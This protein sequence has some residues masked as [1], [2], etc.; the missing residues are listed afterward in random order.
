[1]DAIK[2]GLLE[3]CNEVF[4]SY[5]AI[6]LDSNIVATIIGVTCTLMSTLL[7]GGYAYTWSMSEKEEQEKREWR[8]HH[9]EML[10]KRFDEVKQKQD[11][12]METV[13]D[14]MIDVRELLKQILDEQAKNSSQRQHVQPQHKDR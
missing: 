1:M 5:M 13:N 14:S 12:L 6:R 3:K 10:D 4:S 8:Q 11:K 7:L 2:K 9:S